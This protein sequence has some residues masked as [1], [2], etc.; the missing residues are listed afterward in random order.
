MVVLIVSPS[1]FL[2]NIIKY[3]IEGPNVF[4]LEAA[5]GQEGLSLYQANPVSLSIFDLAAPAEQTV[6]AIS[7]IMVQ[8][9]K[10]QIIITGIPVQTSQI[11]VA[12]EMG[13][14]DFIAKPFSQYKF[15]KHV[16]SILQN[17]A[18]R[19]DAKIANSHLQ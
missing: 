6:A 12:L 17:Q 4:P 3:T 13:A 10:A 16:Y 11:T 8:D 7:Q 2:R 14:I 15:R 19:E 5:S 1:S 9:A 18:L